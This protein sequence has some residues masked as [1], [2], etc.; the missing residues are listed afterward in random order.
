M[1]LWSKQPVWK[2]RKSKVKGFHHRTSVSCCLLVYCLWRLVHEIW[3]ITWATIDSFST[4][5]F[6][7]DYKKNSKSFQLR[8]VWKVQKSQGSAILRQIPKKQQF[9][10]YLARRLDALDDAQVSQHPCHYERHGQL[11]VDLRTL[12]YSAG[13]HQRLAVIVV[14][15]RAAGGTF[16][17]DRDL[18][19]VQL[20]IVNW[21]LWTLGPGKRGS[22]RVEE[23]K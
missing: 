11:P 22:K 4:I 18:R 12:L 16:F 13:V 10:P 17:G 2:R 19:A 9:P 20:T 1:L 14:S 23:V 6:T 8:I 5:W 21:N 7:S 15:S 3:E